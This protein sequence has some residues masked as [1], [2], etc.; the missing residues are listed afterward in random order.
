MN[1]LDKLVDTAG[2]R[3]HDVR[4][5]DVQ[6]LTVREKRLGVKIGDFHDG[7]VL[8][9]GTLEHF[10]FSRVGVARQV[11][12]VG[13]IHDAFDVV[14]V[15]AEIFFE[16]VFHNIGTQV[17]DVGKMVHGRAAGVH[18]D[19]ARRVGDERLALSC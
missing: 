5:F 3:R 17:A 11:S 13:D 18:G 14:A 15:V 7:L 9:A 19:L 4:R 6:F 16:N 1:H 8:S 10:I 2:G 12:D